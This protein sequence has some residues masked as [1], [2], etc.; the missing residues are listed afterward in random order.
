VLAGNC[1]W[2]S[3]VAGQT[4]GAI[5]AA[6]LSNGCFFDGKA[7][8]IRIRG[9]WMRR[10]S[11][12]R[13]ERIVPLLPGKPVKNGGF[14][15]LSSLIVETHSIGA[16]EIPEHEHS[17]FCLH[18]QT[19][20]PVQ[21]EWWSHGKY[22]KENHGPGSMILLTPGTRDRLRWD[23]P[24]R[25]VV[26]SIDESYLHRAALE[27]GRKSHL[28]F[29][30]HWIFEDRQLHLLVS[31]MRREM[32][33]GWE[34]GALYGDHLGMLLSIA[35]IRKYGGDVTVSPVAKGGISRARLQRV[36]DYI[37]ANSHLD[38]KLDNLAEVAGM[39][40]FHFARL[41]R[42]N[43]GI[44]PH[45]Y[46]MDQRM[47]QAKALLQLDSRSVSDIAVE[48]GFANA[49]HFARAFRRYAGVSPTEWKRQS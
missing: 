20:S 26:L 21:M 45:R 14:S 34:M 30:N 9:G 43:M 15:S 42:L 12:I 29:E 25:R 24:S 46:L 47:Q 2:W 7:Q 16:I 13:N 3:A 10:I 1:F 11:V 27:L 6:P 5:S 32:E 4:A 41:F 44:T 17:S 49:G 39:S 33:T 22:G 36:L 38:I 37:A 23:R 40:R 8:N 19:S 31:E 35:L 18:L 48:T 28:G